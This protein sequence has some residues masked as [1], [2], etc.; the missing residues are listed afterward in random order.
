MNNNNTGISTNDVDVQIDETSIPKDP[1]AEKLQKI[2][3]QYANQAAKIEKKKADAVDDNTFYEQ[4]DKAREE[5]RAVVSDATG[6]TFLTRQKDRLATIGDKIRQAARYT[7]INKAADAASSLTGKAATAASSLT[8]KAANAAS[9]VTGKAANVALRGT[10]LLA[11]PITA[12]VGYLYNNTKKLFSSNNSSTNSGTQKNNVHS[13]G[14][15]KK[16]TITFIQDDR[17]QCFIKDYNLCS[18]DNVSTELSNVYDD[19]LVIDGNNKPVK[20]NIQNIGKNQTV[21]YKCDSEAAIVKD[22]NN[23]DVNPEANTDVNPEANTDVN[24]EA[25]IDVNPEA[26]PD[27]NTEANAEP[28]DKTTAE[29]VENKSRSFFPRFI[30]RTGG[31]NASKSI[32]RRKSAK[33]ITKRLLRYSR[34]SRNS[35]NSRK[36]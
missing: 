19:K 10:K 9:S 30:R 14:P 6:N 2:K 32:T 22:V 13:R 4:L 31:Y 7:G 28:D 20:S 29:N 35:R 18:V 36:L 16:I 27:V 1:R 3:A 24:P 26:N 25:N 23:P 15:G 17:N 11:S 12:P 33:P 21:N 8:G 5:G 34:R